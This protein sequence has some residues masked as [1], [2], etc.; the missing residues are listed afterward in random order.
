MNDFMF[1]DD[2]NNSLLDFSYF[3]PKL[4]EM[5]DSLFKN[6]INIQLNNQNNSFSNCNIYDLK[7]SISNLHQKD[8]KIEEEQLSF[9][10]SD[11]NSNSKYSSTNQI[12]SIK[13][14]KPQ[15]TF[16][17]LTNASVK[18]QCNREAVRRYRNRQKK[19]MTSLIN[20]NIMLKKKLSV[21]ENKVNPSALTN[22]FIRSL[23]SDDYL[24]WLYQDLEDNSFSNII[25][26]INFKIQTIKV[27]YE[28]NSSYYIMSFK[29]IELVKKIQEIQS[30][31]LDS[32]IY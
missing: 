18:L 11:N 20:K 17:N 27:D 2:L 24:K 16:T 10:T 28:I 29:L 23:V 19:E 6:T 22:A 31:E 25:D 21:Y 32:N 3:F 13:K 1:E 15:N 26:T 30:R 14:V 12:F 8:K 9:K 7:E 4:S 5:K